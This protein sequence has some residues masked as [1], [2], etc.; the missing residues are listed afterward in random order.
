M[1]PAHYN[2]LSFIFFFFRTEQKENG[3][4]FLSEIKF[5][6]SGLKLK[7]RFVNKNISMEKYYRKK[8]ICPPSHKM[9]I[10]TLH[11]PVPDFGPLH[12]NLSSRRI[13]ENKRRGEEEEEGK[14]GRMS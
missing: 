4:K 12:L 10:V 3:W 7:K 5:S 9:T 13:E 14:G 11:L 1:A 8:S 6:L 2:T